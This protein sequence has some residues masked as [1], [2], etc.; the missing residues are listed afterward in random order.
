MEIFTYESEWVDKEEL[1]NVTK[2][3]KF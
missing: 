3:L 2:T 1:E